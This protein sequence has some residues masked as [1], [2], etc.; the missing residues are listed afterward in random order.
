MR[1]LDFV[2]LIRFLDK[3]FAR[4]SSDNAVFVEAAVVE[5]NLINAVPM[6]SRDKIKELMTPILEETLN[7]LLR[8]FHFTCS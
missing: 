7:E 6:G 5:L 3:C 1:A 2:S 4:L 8:E